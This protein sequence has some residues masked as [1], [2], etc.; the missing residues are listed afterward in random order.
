MVPWEKDAEVLEPLFGANP[1]LDSQLS[2]LS[3][4]R[5]CEDSMQFRREHADTDVTSTTS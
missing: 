4:E 5:I 2:I 1:P 3:E